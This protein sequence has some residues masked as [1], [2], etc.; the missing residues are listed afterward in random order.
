M[1]HENWLNEHVHQFPDL[2]FYTSLSLIARL[3]ASVALFT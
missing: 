2:A 3:T 1:H